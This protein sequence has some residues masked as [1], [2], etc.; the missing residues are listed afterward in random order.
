MLAPRRLAHLRNFMYKKQECL[1]LIDSRNIYTRNHAA[2]VYKVAQPRLDK[3]KQNPLY[4]GAVDWNNLPVNIRNIPSYNQ[5]KNT[6]KNWMISVV[7][8]Q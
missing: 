5:F 2:T 6:Q 3:F 4:R 8:L 7:S 1:D